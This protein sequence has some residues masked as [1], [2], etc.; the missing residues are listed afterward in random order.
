MCGSADMLKQEGAFLCQS[1]GLKYS[2]EEAKKMMIEGTVEVTG[3]VKVDHTSDI[4]PLM[5]R[6][7]MALEDSDSS[8]AFQCFTKARE[9]NP[10]YASAY[11]GRLCAFTSF[12]SPPWEKNDLFVYV[13]KKESD[14]ARY[15][16][17]LDDMPDYQKAIRFAD[18][19]YRAQLEGY[20]NEIK[21]RIEELSKRYSFFMVIEHCCEHSPVKYSDDPFMTSIKGYCYTGSLKEGSV[22]K[23]LRTGKQYKYDKYFYK[24]GS[25]STSAVYP[26]NSDAIRHGD[27]AV[28]THEEEQQYTEQKRRAQEQERVERQRREEQARI[29][30]AE[31]ER[32]AR[33]EKM[34]PTIGLLL[35]LGITAA[36][37]YVVFATDV[38]YSIES[39]AFMFIIPG[40]ISLLLGI[41]SLIFRRNC[42]P[43][44]PWGIIFLS[45]AFAVTIVTIGVWVDEGWEIRASI[46][47]TVI[48][49]IALIVF[50]KV[51]EGEWG[52]LGSVI[53]LI[54]FVVV[55]G[56]IGGIV[57]YASASDNF[58]MFGFALLTLPAIPGIIMMIKAELN[59]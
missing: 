16:R 55:F 51:A 7:W 38:I 13:V 30:Q 6:G 18:E 56:I 11:V 44:F 4:E 25:G 9:I 29:A 23:I 31:Q 3:T 37:L 5:K 59:P 32:I 2:V 33:K 20:N 21:K 48:P 12:K 26:T 15:Y 1:C 41:I 42:Y 53:T 28:L 49:V 27:V 24:S 17:P 50:I 8:E 34:K 54:V 22:F 52:V 39:L 40:V 36:F 47:Q 57:G 35:Q 45:L 58:S 19:T 43:K 14:L 10:E 46:I